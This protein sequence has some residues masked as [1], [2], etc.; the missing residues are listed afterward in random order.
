MTTSESMADREHAAN[1]IIMQIN[2]TQY[3]CA[4]W[5]SGTSVYAL[6]VVQ[7]VQNFIDLRRKREPYLYF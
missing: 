7:S 3:P 2:I 5:E 1:H 4:S 6:A